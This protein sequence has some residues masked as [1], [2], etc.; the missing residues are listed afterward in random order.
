MS[1]PEYRALARQRRKTVV[2]D[3]VLF[4]APSPSPSDAGV[5]SV[6][7]QRT[8]S[9]DD[10]H[11]HQ[12]GGRATEDRRQAE[13]AMCG[14]DAEEQVNIPVAQA[15]PHQSLGTTTYSPTSSYCIFTSSQ[16]FPIFVSTSHHHAYPPSPQ[17]PTNLR[18]PDLSFRRCSSHHLT[19]I[20]A[21]PPIS[22][23]CFVSAITNNHHPIFAFASARVDHPKRMDRAPIPPRHAAAARVRRVASGRPVYVEVDESTAGPGGREACAVV[24]EVD[25][26]GQGEGEG[27][28]G[29]GQWRRWE[30]G[31]AE[32]VLVRRP[33]PPPD[34]SKPLPTLP[35][36]GEHLTTI[37][38]AE[39]CAGRSAAVRSDAI[40][41]DDDGEEQKTK[42]NKK[43][44][45]EE[46]DDD[47]EDDEGDGEGDDE[48]SLVPSP[49]S[50]RSPTVS[51][52]LTPRLPLRR[53]PPMLDL[54]ASNFSDFH[55]HH[56]QH[57]QY[58]HH[59]HHHHRIVSPRRSHSPT[60]ARAYAAI[61]EDIHG[62]ERI[63]SSATN[64]INNN[65][66]STMMIDYVPQW[67]RTYGSVE[68]TY[69]WKTRGSV[70]RRRGDG[71]RQR[72]RG[73]G[74]PWPRSVHGL[75]RHEM[76]GYGD[77]DERVVGGFRCGSTS[78]SASIYSRAVDDA[79]DEWSGGASETSVDGKAEVG[80]ATVIKSAIASCFHHRRSG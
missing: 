7:S 45:E 74:D 79:V 4:S 69:P 28:E 33:T 14:D 75:G 56:H 36:P 54:I 6:A 72:E 18:F 44:Q 49:L 43:I 24:E 41:E 9:I 53:R 10:A 61:L 5:S 46:G 2:F 48:G 25:V 58:Q 47:D 62:L 64:C 65:N 76:R 77:D 68:P 8:L 70:L 16:P 12:R 35:I 31:C 17:S 15:R 11:G 27:E 40:V 1:S 20:Q 66:S 60:T 57:H 26:V 52:T 34:L 30:R 23:A 19:P 13:A 21:W 67:S 78:R 22:S 38:E 50:P 71:V 63:S 29:G 51:T 80:C 55:N 73:Q 32:S 59:N 37:V 39:S 42:N 3:G